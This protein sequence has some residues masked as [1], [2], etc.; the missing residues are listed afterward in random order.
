MPLGFAI[1]PNI[2]RIATEY[3]LGGF[4][5]TGKSVVKLAGIAADAFNPVGGNGTILQ[6]LSPTAIDPLVAIGENK[7]WTKKPIAKESMDRTV[8]GHK[9]WKDTAS[10][11][12]KVAAEIINT[13]SGG[14]KHVAGGLSP[15][16]DQ[17]D[18]LIGQVM[19]GVGREA[20]KLEQSIM[21]T[22]RGEDLPAHKI[23]LIGRFYGNAADQTSQ[24]ATFY[25]NIRRIN[26]LEAEIKG[27]RKEGRGADAAKF[28]AE[29]PEARLM[30]RANYAER[31]VQKLRKEKHDLVEKD[32]PRERIKALEDRIKVEM[33]RFNQAVKESKQRKKEAA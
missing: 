22:Y 28:I 6:I 19:G 8:P 11:P 4:K 7:D 26:E 30:M 1:L 33:T 5:G 23:P 17:I 18:Y 29:N 21:A 13:L 3:A 20:S 15:T 25:N 31:Q 10:T 24:G 12:A 9:L 32:A 14:T 2:G 16:P 27:L